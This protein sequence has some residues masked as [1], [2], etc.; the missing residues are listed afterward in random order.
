MAVV[1]AKD[2]LVIIAFAINLEVVGVWLAAT[3]V[4]TAGRH[5]L[6]ATGG[7]VEQAQH[8]EFHQPRRHMVLQDLASATLGSSI[9][10]LN[11]PANPEP[12]ALAR[13]MASMQAEAHQHDI[14][15]SQPFVSSHRASAGVGISILAAPL[16]SVLLSMMMGLLGGLVLSSFFSAKRFVSPRVKPFIVLVLATAIF[17]S[18]HLLGAEPLLACV[19]MGMWMTNRR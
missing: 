4:Q 8:P 3:D 9:D 1:V 19:T 17:Q 18:T 11:I 15:S 5:L 2:V 10:S 13:S 6:Q 16:L 14:V 7:G 12:A